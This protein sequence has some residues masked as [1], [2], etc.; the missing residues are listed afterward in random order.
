MLCFI[1]VLVDA[2]ALTPIFVR[3]GVK[4]NIGIQKVQKGIPLSFVPLSKRRQCVD[5]SLS[6]CLSTLLDP[7]EGQSSTASGLGKTRFTFVGGKGGVGKTSTSSAIAIASSDAGLRTLVVSTDPAHS[8]GDALQ[9]DLPA[10][11]IT[12]VVSE[13]NLWALELS[14]DQAME[15]LQDLAGGLD[16]QSLSDS[17]GVPKDLIESFGLEDLGSILANPPPGIDEIVALSKIFSLAKQKNPNDDTRPLYD[18]IIVDTAP[19]GHTL[20]LLQ[21]PNF[22]SSLTGK[23]IKFRSK[24][25]VCVCLEI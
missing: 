17:L 18:R 7:V 22:L 11:V 12:P 8:L 13:L 2:F 21:L 3:N 10:G 16:A 23:L 15:E 20:R 1:V 9:L 5:L 6:M 24:I 25:Q 19:T 4:Q 14:V